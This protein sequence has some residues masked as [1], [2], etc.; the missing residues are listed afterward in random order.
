MSE[1]SMDPTDWLPHRA[2]FLLL[3]EVTSIDPDGANGT[4]IW[5]GRF[6]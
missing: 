1:L 6:G 2:P 4:M 5:I 3:D